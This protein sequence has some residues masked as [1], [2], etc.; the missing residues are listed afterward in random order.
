MKFQ[1]EPDLDY[2][3]DAISAVCDLFRGQESQRGEFSISAALAEDKAQMGFAE[4]ALGIANSLNLPADSVLENL[5]ETQ[6]RNG[7][8]RSDSLDSLDFTVEMETGTGK[9]YVY[10]RTIFELN[11]RYGFTKFVVVVPS[12]AIK[13]GVNKSLE[14]MGDHFRS[15][16]SGAPFAH[17]IYDSARMGRVRAFASSPDIEIMV[18]TVG[19][20][21]KPDI[22]SIYQENERTGGE[23]PID[24]VRATSPILI[25]DEPQSVD[26]G[27]SGR[28]REALESMNPLC[29][30]GYSATHV[31]KRHM[32]YRLTA[33]DAFDRKLV[34]RIE[35]AAA[36]VSDDYNTPYIRLVSTR[37]QRGNFI[38]ARIEVDEETRAGSV[39]R[40]VITVQ[41]G[42]DLERRTRRALY[43]DHVI[44][45]L[46]VGRDAIMELSVPGDYKWIRP[47]E[48]Y[49]AVDNAAVHRAM[50]RRAIREHFEK[51]KRLAGEGVKVLTLF[52]IDRV[53]L[54]RDRDADGNPAKGEYAR[55]FEEEYRRLARNPDYA[56]LFG[57]KADL[58]DAAE[59]AHDGYFSIDRRGGWTDTPENHENNQTNRDSSERAYSL[60]MR[61]KEKLLSFDEPLKFIF[62]H[63]ALREGWDNPNVFQICALRDIHSERERRQSIGRGLRLCVNQEGERQRGFEMNTLTVIARESYQEFAENLQREIEVE[64]GFRFGILEPHQFESI[65]ITGDDGRPQWLGMEKSQALFENLRQRGYVDSQGKVSDSLRNDLKSGNVALPP[66]FEDMR[67][68]IIEILRKAAGRIEIADADERRKA[69]PRE[70]VLNG[71][72]FQE[73]WERVKYKTSYSVRFDN[74]TM[75]ERCAE[76]LRN[77]QA[78]PSAKLQWSDADIRIER[79][80]V[81]ADLTQTAAPVALDGASV[82]SPDPLTELQG[83]TQLTRS[84]V[85]RILEDSGRLDDFE[86]NPQKFIEIAA[87]VIN[88][89]KRA[90]LVEGIKYQR[91][92]DD[93]YF[94]QELFQ[95]EE[96]TGYLRN[97]LESQKSVY[98]RVIYDS[99][100]EREFANALEMNAAV[101]VYAKLPN[102]F[103][104]P[105]PLGAYHPDWAA[106]IEDESGERLYFVVETKGTAF[107]DDLRNAERA[108][109]ECGKAHFQS[110]RDVA[111]PPAEYRVVRNLDELM[112]QI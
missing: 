60:I 81:R 110:L 25:V 44:R 75:I 17:F 9:T 96:L 88:R 30:L 82:E 56:S 40:R 91:L 42:D 53:A 57:E 55:I 15:L 8:R 108:K 90:S 95:T 85:Y 77:A 10:L 86:R 70:A 43:R 109:V 38:T 41:D 7:L 3:L 58:S 36:T 102:W 47:G 27:V 98:D 62:S 23:K 48:A 37:R 68:P 100:V 49:G 64:T 99:D 2:Q 65:Q 32:V 20:I 84:S 107:L 104:V 63:S 74:E 50:I 76:S 59:R 89:S 14:M 93:R 35:V 61:D 105:T 45:E 6:R 18:V 46:R 69:N 16:Y 26:G 97:M 52:F 83:R 67:D 80:G 51:E 87:G 13:E 19:A 112:A 101:K 92:G 4:N 12:I 54:Y 21:N 72:D 24:F 31:D 73:L 5:R 78:I 94:C 106:L 39:R 79:A 33:V 66:E 22:N 28:G 11:K 1:F 34:K 29:T 103:S 111:S 71:R